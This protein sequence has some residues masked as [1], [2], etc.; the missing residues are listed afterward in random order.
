MSTSPAF[1]VI[2]AHFPVVVARTFRALS[3]EE[4]EDFYRAYNAI[5]ARHER[6][7]AITDL[8]QFAGAPT[9]KQ[10]QR[11]GVWYN[12][13]KPLLKRYS[14][15]HA[16]VMTSPIMRG[17]MTALRWIVAAEVPEVYVPTM[18]I[19]VDF[20]IERLLLAGIDAGPNPLARPSQ[21]RML[22]GRN[23]RKSA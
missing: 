21:L 17:A 20:C 22:A 6:F 13:T 12:E 4:H 19:A 23:V 14:L 9:A 8:R 3:D 15:G 11:L 16:V 1:E 2:T 5:Y 10:R 7:V 18:D